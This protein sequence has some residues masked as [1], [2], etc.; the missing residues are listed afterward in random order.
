[1]L[2]RTDPVVG[3]GQDQR[4]AGDVVQPVREIE[5]PPLA[6]KP[7]INLLDVPDAP[8]PSDVELLDIESLL[9][10]RHAQIRLYRTFF[11]HPDICVMPNRNE[12]SHL[13]FVFSCC[14]L[15][16]STLIVGE[17]RIC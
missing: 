1:M 15:V 12:N 9:S 14:W 6:A 5:R 7:T 16:Q 4:G 3:S 10:N 11:V 13:D 17:C 8:P 2:R